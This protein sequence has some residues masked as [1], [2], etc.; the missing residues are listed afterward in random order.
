[1]QGECQKRRQ[2][3][4][5]FAKAMADKWGMGHREIQR[6]AGRGQQENRDR[7]SEV[8]DQLAAGSIVIR[9]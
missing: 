2:R 8:R 7:R 1:M 3:A 9:Y 5:A 6:A 4:S